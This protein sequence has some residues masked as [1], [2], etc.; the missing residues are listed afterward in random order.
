VW[1]R[2]WPGTSGRPDLVELRGAWKPA[3]APFDAA[4]TITS[5]AV[6]AREPALALSSSGR[7]LVAW[8]EIAADGSGPL[9]NYAIASSELPFAAGTPAAVP[10]GRETV[11]TEDRV[12]TTWL[13]GGRA[14]VAWD[15]GQ[16]EY[17]D[18]VAPGAMLGPGVAIRK[19]QSG[20]E[21]SEQPVIAGA[22]AVRPVL[23]WDGRSPADFSASAVRY[24]IGA[25]LPSF[26]GPS[27]PSASLVG[28]LKLAQGSV[29]VR[30]TCPEACTAAITATAYAQR[31]EDS[32]SAAAS[33][34]S[35]LGALTHAVVALP[36]GG[37][38]VARL[39]LVRS[40]LKRFCVTTRQGDDEALE[41]IV[42]VQTAHAGERRLILGEEPTSKGCR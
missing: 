25:N 19:F 13:P 12:T 3:D 34:Y 33:A 41:V 9:L 20:S 42:S 27:M 15:S 31:L 23:A 6:E 7:A 22:E 28:K 16:F 30:V 24:V 10:L 2:G 36:A 18:E 39:R 29:A 37:R 40:T 14:L 32:E 21:F 26:A 8:T 17:A 11:L 5:P 35:R 38:K 4:Q 1:L